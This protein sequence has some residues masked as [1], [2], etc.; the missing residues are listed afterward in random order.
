MLFEE[1]AEVV[2]VLKAAP[3]RHLSEGADVYKEIVLGVKETDP[4]P[5]FHGGHVKNL[6]EQ[7]S[8]MG[9][10]QAAKI[11]KLGKGH[12]LPKVGL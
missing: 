12:R 1:A 10:T 4:V 8:E 3:C 11:G 7:T 9:H 5:I 6:E 2:S